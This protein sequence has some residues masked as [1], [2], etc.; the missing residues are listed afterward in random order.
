MTE[1]AS[2][3]FQLAQNQFD[4]IAANLSLDTVLR[5]LLRYPLREHSFLIPV[6]TEN[7]GSH[8][9]RGFRV[10][11]N[12]AR[13]P[14]KGGIRF[15]PQETLDGVRALAM[16]NTWKCAIVDI[17]LGGA[18][19]GVVCDPHTITQDM[20]EKICRGWVR[21]MSQNAGPSI[22]VPEPDVMTNP[23]HM[24]WMLDEFETINHRHA[25]GFITGKPVHLGGSLGRL[26]ATG[27][28]M[29]Y[30]LREALRILD[31]N[32]KST[33]A[34][35]QGFGSVARH[36]ISLYTELGGTVMCI[37]CLDKQ[38]QRPHTFRRKTGIDFAELQG[39]SDSFGSID[40]NRARDLGYEILEDDAWLKEP[41]DIMI[42]AALEYQID[43]GNINH[44]SD[45]VSVIVE[46]ANCPITP[47]ADQVIEKKDILLIPDF[48]AN[49]GGIISSYF[50][51]VQSDSNYYW[52]RD[53]VLGKLDYRMTRTFREVSEAAVRQDQSMRDVALSI[54]ISR[55]AQ[56]CSERGW[57]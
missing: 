9:F 11:H 39:I 54:G 26:E 38:D 46:G 27:Y 36:A 10:Q 18:M 8:V 15:H 34:S 21:Q 22:D 23:R 45:R 2:N 49:S 33:T 32:I 43:G 41:V 12:D 55:V 50:E 53:E 56:A 47:D 25:P 29:I 28:G 44:L 7:N 35:V 52:A 57:V 31:K 19:G 40:K 1:T 13:G 48:V 51:Q 14:C 4:R 37:A 5:E 30:M 17:P 20:Q 24:L 16:W 3:P 6:K 42:P